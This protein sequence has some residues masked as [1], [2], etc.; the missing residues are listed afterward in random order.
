M[1]K[2]ENLKNAVLGTVLALAAAYTYAIGFALLVFEMRAPFN[3]LVGIPLLSL[4]YNFW[5]VIPLGIALGM[6]IPQIASGKAR[7][8]AALQGAALGGVG[9]LMA[10]LCFASISGIGFEGV[11]ILSVMGYSAL[12]VG[13]Y[14]FYC[15]KN[16][17][18]YR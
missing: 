17:S 2:N 3:F 6:L 11:I 10:I 1:M 5:I 12:W 15:A 7:W 14:A 4:S 8:V 16:Q 13:G 18:L 9:G